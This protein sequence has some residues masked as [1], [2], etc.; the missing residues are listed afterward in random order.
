MKF[1]GEETGWYPATIFLA[2]AG[3]LILFKV[4]IGGWIPQF[5]SAFIAAQKGLR[6]GG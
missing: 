1:D 6:I 2:A 5:G 3:G 4:G